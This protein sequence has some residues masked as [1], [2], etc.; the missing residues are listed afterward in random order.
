MD[1]GATTGLALVKLVHDYPPILIRSR[2]A[3]VSPWDAVSAL[4]F[5]QTMQLWV[6]DADEVA[7][8]E[9]STFR[10]GSVVTPDQ[11]KPAAVSALVCLVAAGLDRPMF[12]YHPKTVRKNVAG[13]GSAGDRV[14]RAALKDILRVDGRLV[15]KVHEMDAVAVALYAGRL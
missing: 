4:E 11:M 13:S 9:L 7:V 1:P 6:S 2:E 10:A 3:R 12:R 14:M 5:A 8:E 15:M